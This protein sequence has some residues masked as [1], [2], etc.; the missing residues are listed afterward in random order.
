MNDPL[1]VG[2]QYNKSI[3]DDGV[4]DKLEKYYTLYNRR[5]YVHPDPLEFLYNYRA[6]KDIEIVGLIA[7]SL[8]F[9]RVT[10]IL[11]TVSSVLGKMGAS[12]AVY[13]ETSSPKTIERDFKGFV[14]RFVRED[15]ITALLVALKRVLGDF[16]S[17]E[18]CFKD[19]LAETDETLINALISFDTKIRKR[20][21]KSP[22]Y[23]AADP[24]KGSGC[25]RMNLFL[26]WMIRKDEVDLGIWEGLSPSML[27]IPVDTHM[28]KI[29]LKLNLTK[30]K[31]ANMKTA[32]EITKG[33]AGINPHDPV[34][35]DFSLTRFGIRDDLSFNDI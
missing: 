15:E 3:R 12:P 5:Q 24:S 31:Q 34:K 35:Y 8:A 33:F 16:N 28:H 6:K 14:Y 18:D 20:A 29:G 25:K 22:G 17:I 13:L 23:L 11:K 27:I 2:G 21:G 4:R 1:I 7:S 10:Q 30:R 32:L 19:G 9:G 26:R